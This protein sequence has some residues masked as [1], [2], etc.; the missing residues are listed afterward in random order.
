[1][2]AQESLPERPPV[3]PGAQVYTPAGRVFVRRSGNPSGPKLMLLHGW[4]VH[5]GMYEGMR[6]RLERD[7][8]LLVPDARGHG[9]SSTPARPR[10][11][12]L[13]DYA[14][15]LVAVLDSLEIDRVHLG[16]YSMGGFIALALTQLAPE[17]IERLA[18]MCSAARQPSKAQRHLGFA[19]A[20]F[21]ILPAASMQLVA[22]RLLAGPG[23]RPDM[24][25]VMMWLLGYNTR[26]GLSGAAR[27]MRRADLRS[28]LAAIR[29][30][31][32]LVTAEHDKAIPIAASREL[33]D[34]IPDVTH[35]HWDD[36]GHALVASHGD[37]LAEALAGFF[38][39]ERT[40]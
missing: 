36:A 3:W 40:R 34:H 20:A 8:E 4:G 18:I 38:A 39:S 25:R 29:Q 28:G 12:E 10:S 35:R 9:Y 27:A 1:M 14:R 23:T 5:G 17:R 33:L 31:T 30:P 6:A 11:W 32:L 7:F 26:G 22:K 2:T 15:D 13:E 37:E 16:G 24:E 21:K 19:E